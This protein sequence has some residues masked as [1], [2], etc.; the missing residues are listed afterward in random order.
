M[1]YKVYLNKHSIITWTAI[2]VMRMLSAYILLLKIL[3]MEIQIVMT[4]KDINIVMEMAKEVNNIS[5]IN[6]L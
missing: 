1:M 6:K 4:I 3:K 5:K 2:I